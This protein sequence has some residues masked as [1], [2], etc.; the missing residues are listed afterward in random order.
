M[1]MV[2]IVVI[3]IDVAEIR[4]GPETARCVERGVR[5]YYAPPL[6]KYHVNRELN[7]DRVDVLPLKSVDAGMSGVASKKDLRGVRV[8]RAIKSDEIEEEWVLTRSGEDFD[9]TIVNIDGRDFQ[10]TV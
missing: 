6:R 2:A 10:F 4:H 8:D 7:D 9:L 3:G 5:L 1:A